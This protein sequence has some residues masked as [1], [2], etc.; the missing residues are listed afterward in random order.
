MQQEENL[1]ATEGKVIADYNIDIDYEGSEPKNGPDAQEKKERDSDT[2]YAEIKVSCS[3]TFHQRMM[4]CNILQ[5]IQSVHC[6][7]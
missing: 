3:G 2:E 5:R 7:Q 1:D 4:H 6:E